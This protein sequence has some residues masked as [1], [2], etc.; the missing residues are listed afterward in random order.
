MKRGIRQCPWGK[1][2]QCRAFALDEGAECG[3]L[4]QIDPRTNVLT[5]H[6]TFPDPF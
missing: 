6:L 2:L 5:D 3:T 4:G 1:T